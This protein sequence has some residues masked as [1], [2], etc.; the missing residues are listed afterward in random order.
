MTPDGLR[1]LMPDDLGKHL[2]RPATA[3]R[4]DV[5]TRAADLVVGR[6]VEKTA[7]AYLAAVER[8]EPS[9]DS[10]VGPPS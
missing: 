1:N 2:E 7:D 4:D 10:P 5:P 8:H 9:A 6:G 3:E